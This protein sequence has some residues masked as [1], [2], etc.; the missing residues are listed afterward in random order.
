ML[1]EPN[2]ED[3]VPVMGMDPPCYSFTSFF[4]YLRSY[5]LKG[6]N[7]QRREQLT[8]IDTFNVSDIR[9]GQRQT[10]EIPDS[11]QYYDRIPITVKHDETSFGSLLLKTEKCFSFGARQTSTRK[12]ERSMDG[13]CQSACMTKKERHQTRYHLFKDSEKL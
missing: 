7:M 12:Q 9:F 4:S 3:N 6:N 8:N 10:Y 11:D 2:E 13:R 5:A 1:D